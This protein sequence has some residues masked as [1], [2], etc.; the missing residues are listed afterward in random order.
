MKVACGLFQLVDYLMVKELNCMAL[1]LGSTLCLYNV[2]RP[3]LACA[4]STHSIMLLCFTV[5]RA[6]KADC[7][8][9]C[10]EF[11]ELLHIRLQDVTKLGNLFGKCVNWGHF[12]SI[13]SRKYL[14]NSHTTALAISLKTL[15]ALRQTKWRIRL[16]MVLTT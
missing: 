16:K 5:A 3:V 4:G 12:S 8:L 14:N 9:A 2:C 13:T 15:T 7:F 11:G 6:T 10:C 1:S